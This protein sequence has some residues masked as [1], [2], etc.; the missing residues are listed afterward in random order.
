M[1]RHRSDLE[2]EANR[3]A[4]FE[5]AREAVGRHFEGVRREQALVF[6]RRRRG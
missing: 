5:A 2:S 1:Q 3:D 4:L 6:A